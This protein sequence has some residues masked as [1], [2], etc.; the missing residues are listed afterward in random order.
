MSCKEIIVCD[1]V[2]CV[3][4]A[5][6]GGYEGEID[7]VDGGR[8]RIFLACD[9]EEPGDPVVMKYLFEHVYRE[10]EAW[11][12]KAID[13]ACER[14]LPYFYY[15]SGFGSQYV[16]KKPF[17]EKL[18]IP[19]ALE[20]FDEGEIHFVFK[21]VTIAS[22]LHFFDVAGTTTDGFTLLQDNGVDI[23]TV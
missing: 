21:T 22:K 10:K 23:P 3:Y 17:F 6:A 16:M 19:E 2:K 15:T 20:L 13:F 14:F 4:S 1:D 18:L 5:D 11:T 7:W 9:P 12:K 8:I